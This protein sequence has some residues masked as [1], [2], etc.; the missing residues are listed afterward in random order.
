MAVGVGV[1]A[2]CA[3]LVVEHDH[4]DDEDEHGDVQQLQH[5]RRDIPK[6]PNRAGEGCERGV[7]ERGAGEGCGVKE[8]GEG[9]GCGVRERGTRVSTA[10]TK[11]NKTRN[12]AAIIGVPGLGRK[13]GRSRRAKHT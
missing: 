9:E 2:G 1:G 8:R 12:N 13:E 4:I 10:N 3:H 5:A 7:R 6:A 11:H